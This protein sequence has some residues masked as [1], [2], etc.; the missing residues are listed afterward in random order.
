MKQLFTVFLL[1]SVLHNYA[2]T[3]TKHYDVDWQEVN[4]GKAMY[5]AEF[6][7][8]ET[9]YKCLSYWKSTKNKRE[10][11][12]YADTSMSAPN[13]LQKVYHKNG[14]L[15]DSILFNAEGKVTEAYHYYGNRQLECHYIASGNGTGT[16]KEA[17]DESGAK[18]KNYLY[19]R[20][21]EPKGGVK[22]WQSFLQK[23]ASKELT[24]GDENSRK[25][26]LQIRFII[27]EEGNVIKAKVIESSGMKAVDQDAVRV[28]LE[29][30]RWTPAVYKNKPIRFPL[31]LPIT[32]E[33]NASKN[34]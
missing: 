26:K 21:A 3:I 11:S 10:E 13:G 33:L 27:D 32:Y 29:S 1:F 4:P 30:P 31:T 6:T 24:S 25:A 8:V 7:K 20:S 19:A 34:K 14:N 9:G 22:G 28:V 5:Y 12:F 16:V 18:I 23:N 17:Y 2:Q 15:E